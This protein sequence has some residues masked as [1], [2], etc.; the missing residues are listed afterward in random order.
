MSR[1]LAGDRV[2]QQMQETLFF[3]YTL[4]LYS[5]ISEN[6]HTYSDRLNGTN[7]C[8]P[9]WLLCLLKSN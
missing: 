1:P 4:P 8:P 9:H 3:S 5:S 6:R 7:T 2:P